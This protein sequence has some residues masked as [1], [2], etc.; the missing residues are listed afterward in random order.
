MLRVVSSVPTAVPEP[1]LYLQKNPIFHISMPYA[2]ISSLPAF[3]ARS[4]SIL[5]QVFSVNRT[6]IDDQTGGKISGKMSRWFPISEL[7]PQVGGDERHAIG[8]I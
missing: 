6:Q 4:I 3:L 2:S 8:L 7:L 5:F 1:R